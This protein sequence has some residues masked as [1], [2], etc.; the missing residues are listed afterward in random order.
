LFIPKTNVFFLSSDISDDFEL[1]IH[2][3]ETKMKLCVSVT[4][5]CSINRTCNYIDYQR[6]PQN[7]VVSEFAGIYTSLFKDGGLFLSPKSE[8]KKYW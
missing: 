5:E 6:F 8:Y 4:Q 3:M 2:I 7:Y 1:M